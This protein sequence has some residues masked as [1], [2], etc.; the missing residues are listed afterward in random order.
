MQYNM[1]K[2]TIRG[3]IGKETA[4]G[5]TSSGT[6][7]VRMTVGVTLR[8]KQGDE[9]VDREP[10]WYTVFRYG[11]AG[12][13]EAELLNKGSLVQVTGELFYDTTEKDGRT[14]HN[15]TITADEILSLNKPP[16][17]ESGYN[18]QNADD[19]APPPTNMSD[20]PF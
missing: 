13:R 4:K 7:Y 20:I 16:K 5:T 19:F 15:M 2:I 11:E 17:S 10:M 6:P 14:F 8:R 1:S 9:W 18:S 12:V 3:H